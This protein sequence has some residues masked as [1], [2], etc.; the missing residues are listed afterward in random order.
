MVT[1]PNLAV[2]S[3]AE[4]A[5][6]LIAFSVNG[7]KVEVQ[8]SPA[9]RLSRILRDHLGLTGTKVG[10]DAGDCGA[11]TVL[12]NGEPVCSCLVAAGQAAGCEVVTVEGLAQRPPLYDRLQKSFLTHGAAQCGVCTPGMLVAATALLDKNLAPSEAEVMDAIGGVLCRCTGYRKI[13]DAIRG[14]CDDVTVAHSPE[15]GTAVGKRLVR[16]DGRKKVEGTEIFGA[17]ETPA[18]ALE[19][20]VIRS[21][22]HRARFQF[23]D[24][25]AFVRAHAGVCAV[26]TSKDVPGEDCYGVIARFA[27]QPVFAHTEARF[28]G[29]AI[30]A[31]AGEAATLEALAPASFP[32]RWEELPPLKMVSEALAAGAPQIHAHRKDN[33]LVEGRV[34]RGDVEKALAGADFV[35]DGEYETGFV[36]HACIEPEAGFARRVG[37]TVEIQACTQSPYLDRD[38]IAKILGIPPEKVRIIPTAVGGGFGTKLDLSVQPFLALAAWKLNRPVRLVYSR[39]ESIVST[40]KRHPAHLRLR[41]GA[42]RDGK[43]T[44]LDF[45]ADFNTG[46]YS[47]WGPTVAAR[48]PVHASGPYRVPNY[49]AVT[50]A[51]HTNLVP[52]GAFRGFGV[53]QTAIAQEQLYDDLADRVGMDRLEFRILNV[54]DNHSATVTGQVLGEGVGIRACFEALR[55]KWQTARAQTAEFNAKANG[56]LRRGVGVAGMWY[57]CGNTSLPNPSTVRIGLKRDG[58]IALHQGAVDI[59]QGS[60]TIVA[61]ICADAIGAPISHLD[62]VS[63]DT[64]ITPDCGKTSAS[65]QTLVTGK[66]AFLAGKQLRSE[67][68]RMAG[69]CDRA[70]IQFGDSDVTVNEE[71]RKV[72]LALESLPLDSRG[73][74]IT[75]EATFDPPTS[76]LDENGQGIPYAVFGFGAHMAEVEVDV[77]LGTVRVLKVTAAHDVGR[78]INPTLIEGQIEG[79]VAQGLGMALMEEFFPGKGENLHDYLI[80]SAGDIPPIESIL[81]EDASSI[82]PFGAKGIGEQAVIPT[83]PAILNAIH[84]ATGVRLRKTPATPDRLRAAI[85][86]ARGGRVG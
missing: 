4:A 60:N 52:A 11:C 47:S 62:L 74:V 8:A 30:A 12:L 78:A 18:G 64:A 23:G 31:I 65:R 9:T 49:R 10:C 75:T 42:T 67:L 28:R 13:I 5:A 53:P 84:D 44:A 6:V 55:P 43:L 86:A 20:R 66:A 38:D 1:G 70:T 16:L 26:F 3:S 32:V 21:P 39:T 27:D 51:V 83:A 72:S 54:L 37:D 56:P 61:Q 33:V 7:R 50:R 46:A 24:L 69:A 58:R 45:A 36:E 82:G 22:H 76:P 79:G 25:D 34:A 17:D 59:G 2:E 71:N 41:A 63:G 85:L 35:V 80:P 57:G 14:A 40:T 77:E 81:I 73:Y 48:V 15:A 29:E 19:V 68:L